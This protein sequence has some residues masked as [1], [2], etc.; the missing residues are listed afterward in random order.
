M[1][2]ASPECVFEKANPTSQEGYADVDDVEANTEVV[3]KG[4]KVSRHNHA[5]I[6]NFRESLVFY[7]S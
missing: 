7:Q 5:K 6:T 4:R 1:K 3:A 2:Y